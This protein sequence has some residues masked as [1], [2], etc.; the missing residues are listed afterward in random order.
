MSDVRVTINA[1]SFGKTFQKALDLPRFKQSANDIVAQVYERAKIKLMEEF[2]NSPITQEI[3]AGPEVTD[4]PSGLL[5]GYGGLFSFIGFYIGDTPIANL[6][7]Y[8]AESMSMRQ[9]V[10]RE[11]KWYFRI[12]VPSES[13][14]AAV[15]PLPWEEGN[16]WVLGVEKEGI[17]NL[18]HYLNTYWP[19]GRSSM[20]IQIKGEYRPGASMHT[21]PYLLGMLDNF[22]EEMNFK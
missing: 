3:E 2:N 20:G 9:T 12:E 16:S 5:D 21:S 17:S 11:N 6:R 13:D 14:I 19:Q 15:T 18:S 10:R 8:L 1:A 22:R 4:D 7:E